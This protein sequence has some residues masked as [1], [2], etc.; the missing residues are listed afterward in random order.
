MLLKAVRG[1]GED[2]D[3]VFS[4]ARGLFFEKVENFVRRRVPHDLHAGVFERVEP[5]LRF[6]F[7]R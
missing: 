5:L 2:E 1:D 7:L 4:R 6:C 3:A